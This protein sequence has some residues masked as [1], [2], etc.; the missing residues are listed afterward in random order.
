MPHREQA[1]N[2]WRRVRGEGGGGGSHRQQTPLGPLPP[3]VA[4][5]LAGDSLS[6]RDELVHGSSL[7][8]RG[9]AG[10]GDT[11]QDWLV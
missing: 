6:L 10:Q 4:A 1:W 3:E 11:R 7:P 2:S 8:R 9:V 5:E